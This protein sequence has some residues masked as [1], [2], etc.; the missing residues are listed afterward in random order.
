MLSRA[1]E[2]AGHYVP[3]VKLKANL[4]QLGPHLSGYCT[5]ED[6]IIKWYVLSGFTILLHEIG[7]AYLRHHN[8][9]LLWRIAIMEEVEA[10]LWAEKIARKEKITFE[11]ETA[12]GAFELYFDNAK[13]R[14][15][16]FINWHWKPKVKVADPEQK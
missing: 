12:E 5:P 16:V 13:R 4:T 3:G 1:Y 6:K 7:H 15:M 8:V 11:Y 10:W 2:L 9:R 14:Q